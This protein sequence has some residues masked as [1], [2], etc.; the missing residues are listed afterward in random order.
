MGQKSQHHLQIVEIV[1]PCCHFGMLLCVE[2]FVYLTEMQVQM[3]D[4]SAYHCIKSHA[5]TFVVN[6]I[7]VEFCLVNRTDYMAD[8]LII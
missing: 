8:V 3:V 5:A 7:V 4:V 2:E 1:Q 6:P